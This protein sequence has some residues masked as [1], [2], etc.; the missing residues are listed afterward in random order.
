MGESDKSTV[1]LRAGDANGESVRS[2]VVS[3]AF[4]CQGE[5]ASVARFMAI[6][7]GTLGGRRL[8]CLGGVT[9]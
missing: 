8:L 2:T 9:T 7:G 6:L 1:V 3:K 4:C 5:M